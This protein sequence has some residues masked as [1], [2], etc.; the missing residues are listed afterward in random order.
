MVE[1][2]DTLGK[3]LIAGGTNERVKAPLTISKK[4]EA[5]GTTMGK[6]IYGRPPK[7]AP[8]NLKFGIIRFGTMPSGNGCVPHDK[9]AWKKQVKHLARSSEFD[10]L[11][12]CEAIERA[13]L[14]RFHARLK[15]ISAANARARMASAPWS[16]RFRLRGLATLRLA[17]GVTPLAVV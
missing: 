6:G 8:N 11:D 15:P 16:V 9:N 13:N 1:L 3:S 14:A 2:V 5:P 4:I 17:A 7:A 12:G 10:A